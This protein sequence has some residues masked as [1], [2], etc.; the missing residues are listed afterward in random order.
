MPFFRKL[1]S[2]RRG[3]IRQGF[4][5][6]EKPQAQY[7]EKQGRFDPTAPSVVELPDPD[8]KQDIERDTQPGLPEL[9]GIIMRRP[10][11]AD[12]GPGEESP[13]EQQ[14][15][16]YARDLPEISV[17]REGDDREQGDKRRDQEA[18]GT[19]ERPGKAKGQEACPSRPS[20]ATL[21]GDARPDQARLRSGALASLLKRAIASS[22]GRISCVLPPSPRKRRASV[23]SSASLRP[24]TAITGTLPTE[25]SR[26]L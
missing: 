8:G 1:E 19:A 22:S 2:A 10:G 14:G 20:I 26:T 15:P 11:E 4:R 7:R 6:Q 9:A 12:H 24:T 13:G 25:C 16:G 17:D 21:H 5:K 23:P 18:A 3:T